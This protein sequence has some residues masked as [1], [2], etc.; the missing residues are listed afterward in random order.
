MP[1]GVAHRV[2]GYAE[3][4]SFGQYLIETFGQKKIKEFY[5]R[6]DAKYRPW[7]EVFGFS[8]N[9]LEYRWLERVKEK[10]AEKQD[11]VAT[12]LAYWKKDPQTACFAVQTQARSINL[13]KE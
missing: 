5:R 6:T 8:L 10:T 9:E 2:P 12:L 1:I 11:A 4:G 7:K 3:V 13:I